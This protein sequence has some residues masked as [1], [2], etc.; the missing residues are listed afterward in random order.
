M[1]FRAESWW[2]KPSKESLVSLMQICLWFRKTKQMK[3][4]ELRGEKK[5]FPNYVQLVTKPQLLLFKQT[6]LESARRNPWKEEEAGR[7]QRIPLQVMQVISE[8]GKA[9]AV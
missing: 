8:P 1:I 3:H 7:E 5:Q 9:I 2:G 6:G 4:L